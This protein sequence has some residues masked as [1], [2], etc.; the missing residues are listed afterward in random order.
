MGTL[1][2]NSLLSGITTGLT[3]TYSVLANSA[4]T[5][6]VTLQSILT[7]RSD[8][9]LATSLNSTFASYIQT[10]FSSLDKDSDGILSSTELSSATSMMAASGM[11]Q[12]QL[13]QLGTAS[14]MSTETLQQVLDHFSEI[15]VNG[16]GKVTSA[17]I[18]G[19]N[20]TSAKEKKE[21]EFRNKFATDMS[22]MYA[23]ENASSAADSS[24][25]L[26]YKYLKDD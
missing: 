3:G 6:G 14:G 11:T 7:S 23:D 21:T 2:G 24:S 26:S 10:N 16:D 4:G 19:Y 5:N 20:L 1:S 12:A 18:N 25:L 8:S 17:E 15:D 22:I 9:S 13:T